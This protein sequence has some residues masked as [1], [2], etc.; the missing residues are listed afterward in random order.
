MARSRVC[1]GQFLL[2]VDVGIHHIVDVS[3]KLDPRTAERDDTGR[4][5]FGTVGVGALSEETPGERW[6]CETTTRSA[7]LMT[8]VPFLGHVGN[9]PR[10]T[11]WISPYRNP[12]GRGRYSK[13]SAWPSEAPSRSGHVPDIRRWYSGRVDVV[14]E[15]FEHEVVAGVGYREVFREDLV[16]ALIVAFSGGVSSCRKSWNDFSCTSRK[17]G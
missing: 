9:G 16:Q 5:E 13:A 17:S 15:K 8:K 2:T 7:P 6:S 11:S 3:C 1:N 10:Y 14:V 12:R 4:V